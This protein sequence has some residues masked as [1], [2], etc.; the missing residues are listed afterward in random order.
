MLNSLISVSAQNVADENAKAELNKLKSYIKSFGLMYD[1]LNMK[2]SFDEVN[3]SEYTEA[4]G[5]A[6]IGNQKA[7]HTKLL[8]QAE[9]RIL[10]SA[11]K[12]ILI[13]LIMNELITNSLKYAY[14]SVNEKGIEISLTIAKIMPSK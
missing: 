7:E 8:Y 4:I 1:N 14:P 6:V 12:A 9:D 10:I 13:G 3:L 5:K 11:D 2:L